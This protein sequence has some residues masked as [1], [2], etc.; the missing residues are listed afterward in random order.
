[1]CM[2]AVFP[3]CSSQAINLGGGW[4]AGEGVG[5]CFLVSSLPSPLCYLIL[6][7]IFRGWDR[8][9]GWG[10]EDVVSYTFSIVGGKR[11]VC[12]WISYYMAKIVKLKFT[13]RQ[14]DL[15]YF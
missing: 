9:L 6:L 1:M 11:N 14:Y 13:E 3:P 15:H 10:V 4:G 12:H 5:Q 8:V 7:I 2:H